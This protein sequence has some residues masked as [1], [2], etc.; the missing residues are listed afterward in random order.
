M[1]E[2]PNSSDPPL[3]TN[4]S[5]ALQHMPIM[6]RSLFAGKHYA[7]YIDAA[8]PH[9]V[10]TR[11]FQG[12][13]LLRPTKELNGIV[14][15]VI[16]RAQVLYPLVRLYAYAFLSNHV[17]L[18][19]QGP[20]DQFVDFVAF[21]KREI[22]R[23]HGPS[24]QWPGA[25]WDKYLSAALP[26][27]ASQMACFKYVLSQGVKEGLVARPEEWPGVHVAKQFVGDSPLTG[28]WFDGTAFAVAKAHERQ[29]L[30]P[31]LSRVRRERFERTYTV[32]IDKLPSWET[33]TDDEYRARAVELCDEI[34]QEAH[35]A[36]A[37]KPVL[38]VRGILATPIDKQFNL[39]L[40]SWAEGR[41]HKTCWEAT[42]GGETADYVEAY[43]SYQRAYRLAADA[44]RA[45]KLD[46]VF[47]PGSFR[48]P[49]YDERLRRQRAG[50]VLSPT[51][52]G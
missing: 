12:R 46:V 7:R 23:R 9:H 45:G 52:T 41:R 21:V 51:G 25:L 2:A 33:D 35:V 8:L 37:G 5:D 18:L 6:Q 31:N 22:S 20:P 19:M 17:H 15:G 28:T 49:V 11:V 39:H 43:W 32:R 48:P 29:K 13:C 36:R 38:G 30:V 3:A 34:V 24:V 50:E 42:D 27:P 1:Q 16:G 47:P 26:S 44:Y 40:P 14:A 4:V 10:I